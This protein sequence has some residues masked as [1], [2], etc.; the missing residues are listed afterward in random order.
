MV[1]A[2]LADPKQK[3]FFPVNLVPTTAAKRQRSTSTS[4][5]FNKP[6][7]TDPHCKPQHQQH[8]QHQQHRARTIARSTPMSSKRVKRDTVDLVTPDRSDSRNGAHVDTASEYDRLRKEVTHKNEVLD[9]PWR[10]EELTWGAR[11]LPLW[12]S[13]WGRCRGDFVVGFVQ[14]CSIS[15]LISPAD[16]CSVILYTLSLCSLMGISVLWIGSKKRNDVRHVENGS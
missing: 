12:R 3:A 7:K 15:R 5:A 11:S 14:S 16:M 10:E 9:L 13:L 4:P 2:V 8:Q 6:G 1:I